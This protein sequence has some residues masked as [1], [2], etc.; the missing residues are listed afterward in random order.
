MSFSEPSMPPRK[1]AS[2]FPSLA[3]NHLIR[4]VT[5]VTRYAQCYGHA[6]GSAAG[7]TIVVRQQSIISTA[8][9]GGSGPN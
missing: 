3:S 4:T 7:V 8:S 1:T 5:A 6:C 2:A 9:S